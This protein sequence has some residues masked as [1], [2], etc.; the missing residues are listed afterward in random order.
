MDI[1]DILD[2]DGMLASIEEI[3]EVVAN[4]FAD[5]DALVLM[6]ETKEGEICHR[7]YG[8]STN[9]VGLLA[10]AQYVILR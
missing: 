8:S 1:K 7:G 3:E 6:W 5:L 10:K 9:I 4:R 2:R